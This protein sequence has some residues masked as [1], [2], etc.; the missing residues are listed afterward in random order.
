MQPIDASP[1]HG[2]SG[3]DD[4]QMARLDP[5]ASRLKYR[6]ERLMLTPLV[7]FTLRVVLPFGLCLGAGTAW[8]AV[9]E[10]REK[11]QLMLS[12]VKAT[13]EERPE[14]QV[15]LMAIDGASEALAEQIRAQVPVHL[16]Q[17]SFD[18]DLDKIQAQ[19]QALNAVKTAELRIRQGGVL[20]LDVVQRV[21]RVLL[22]TSDGLH[23]LDDQGVFVA[24]AAKR[25]DHP[26]LPVMAGDILSP[27]EAQA[28]QR[29]HVGMTSGAAKA[30]GLS[31]D[32]VAL[33]ATARRKLTQAVEEVRRFYA[34]SGPLRSR[35]RGFERMGARRWDVVLDRDQRILL[36]ETRA[37]QALEWAIS[38]AVTRSVDL[39]ARDLVA[40]DLR[41]PHRP[42]VRMTDL[43]TQEMWRIKAI[44]AGRKILR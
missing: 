31:A 30:E 25:I 22:R 28:M 5:G 32:D 21:P 23:L 1:S 44:E 9:D 33:A 17:S 39:L 41:L 11:F 29:V 18:L 7:R 12:E 8:F 20:Q 26:D 42:T 2:P 14:F 3:G 38:M 19:V 16:P 27:A 6:L 13:V 24:V 4:P 43:A 36:P 34:L 37:E 40:V 15:R 10:N 35:L